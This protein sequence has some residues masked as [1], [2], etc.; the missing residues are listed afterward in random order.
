[1]GKLLK[2][3]ANEKAE[4]GL[5][6]LKNGSDGKHGFNERYEKSKDKKNLLRREI[7]AHELL[8]DEKKLPLNSIVSS[9]HR[10]LGNMG[11]NYTDGDIVRIREAYIKYIVNNADIDISGELY[12][13][14]NG[15]LKRF[16]P[17]PIQFHYYSE[18]QMR[19]N[20]LTWLK[21]KDKITIKPK[22]YPDKYYAWYHG[23]CMAIGKENPFPNNFTKQEIIL[24][25]KN[26]YGTGEGFYKTI[27]KLDL[28][29]TFTFVN[30]L[31]PKERKDW[32][33]RLIE[34]SSNDA[35]IVTYL[36]KFLN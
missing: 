30:S 2:A 36:H 1:M 12:K 20:Y 4:K 8:F 32:K 31:T 25:G 23:I 14:K 17:N 21:E 6:I 28:T 19:F 7:E 10:P 9:N 13:K 33:E 34:I 24:L 27:N 15:L 3:M 18:A 16:R 11:L 5:E 35:D 26:K 22:E 29:Q